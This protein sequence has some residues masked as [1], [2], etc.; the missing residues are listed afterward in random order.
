M[1]FVDSP[2]PLT[3]HSYLLHTLRIFVGKRGLKCMQ[4]V[5]LSSTY[6][7]DYLSSSVCNLMRHCPIHLI[8]LA[9]GALR[10]C[11]LYPAARMRSDAQPRRIQCYNLYFNDS[12][13]WC[14]DP[15]THVAHD[16]APFQRWGQRWVLSL[17]FE[18][19]A[20]QGRVTL[21]PKPLPG[22]RAPNWL[23]L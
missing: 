19:R 20:C 13:L 12:G 18:F 10:S 14:C 17:I 5:V 2:D 22:V 7:S 9:D 3:G 6:S 21:T 4:N 1:S 23:Y 16:A 11:L 15:T 8:P